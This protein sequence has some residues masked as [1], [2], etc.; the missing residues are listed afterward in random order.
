V[1]TFRLTEPASYYYSPRWSPDSKRIAFGDRSW[2]S[3]T[4]TWTRQD[5]EVDTT[6]R[7]PRA[8]TV[9]HG[10]RQQLAGLYQATAQHAAGGVG[11]S[12]GKKERYQITDG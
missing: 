9:R 7:R 2:A 3:T 5:G 11:V 12:L 6:L 8:W 4:R 1:R 10:R